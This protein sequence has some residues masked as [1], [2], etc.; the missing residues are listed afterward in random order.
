MIT[1]LNICNADDYWEFI[2][3][4]HPELSTFVKGP[5]NT[6]FCTYDD[7]SCCYLISTN[8]G[9]DWNEIKIDSLKYHFLSLAVN[10]SNGYIFAG[11]DDNGL[12][13]STDQG[14]SWQR[15]GKDSIGSYCIPSVFADNIGNVFL[16]ECG[17]HIWHSPDNGE[18]WERLF[19]TSSVS[20]LMYN[21]LWVKEN[22]D[23]FSR[24]GYDL[25]ISRDK[26]YNWKKM[27]NYP[28]MYGNLLMFEGNENIYTFKKDIYKSSNSGV[29]WE[30]IKMVDTTSNVIFFHIDR[31][32][33]VLVGRLNENGVKVY[34]NNGKDDNWED[35]STGMDT[36]NIQG[37]KVILTN[38]NH[39]LIL[40]GLGGFYRSTF[41][42]GVDDKEVKHT[43]NN[44][45]PNPATDFISLPE[46]IAENTVIEIYSGIGV[47][48]YTGLAEKHINISDFAP[49]VYYVKAGTVVYKFVKMINH[50]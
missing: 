27:Q 21:S 40:A 46:N 37:S 22:G 25:N 11:T 43:S 1:S 45:F 7:F 18:T 5:G 10:Y 31:N 24:F 4:P 42:V 23:M 35:I 48:L 15:L 20:F 34:I 39:Y 19:D 2:P 44:I 41:T 16:V 30:K 50:I 33:R 14:S 13:R 29:S 9:I 26:G 36:N 12:L 6:I 28:Y 47:K 8:N 17:T 38:D 32:N 49:G 3:A